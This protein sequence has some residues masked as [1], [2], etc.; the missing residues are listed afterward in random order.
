MTINDRQAEAIRSVLKR[1]QCRR[2]AGNIH[3]AVCSYPVDGLPST[4]WCD[5]CIARDAM[6]RPA[7]KPPVLR[8][9]PSN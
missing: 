9:R 7:D 3:L 8:A 6:K 2:Q 4:D 5:T 1:T